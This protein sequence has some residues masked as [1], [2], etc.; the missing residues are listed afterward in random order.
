MMKRKIV[1]LIPDL[2]LGGAQRQCLELASALSKYSCY[3]VSIVTFRHSGEMLHLA[4]DHQL[5]IQNLGFSSG[6][7]IRNSIK[8]RKYLIETN[9]RILVTW[10][11]SADV[12]GFF[13]T[14]FMKVKWI[15]NERDSF[16]PLRI[17]YIARIICCA[18]ASSIIANSLQGV[19]Y[20]K[21]KYFWKNVSLVNN[22]V[23][24]QELSTASNVYDVIFG[25][26]FTTQ[27]RAVETAV[28]LENLVRAKPHL[29]VAMVGDGEHFNQV[30]D[31]FGD[32]IG[33][34]NVDLIGYSIRFREILGSSKTLISLSSHEG[35][36]NVVLEGL[37]QGVVP[38]L[39]DIP[40]HVAI[41]GSDYPFL[42]SD[43]TEIEE[44]VQLVLLAISTEDRRF[45][46]KGNEYLR[47]C[48]PNLVALNAIKVFEEGVS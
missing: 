32:S 8:L 22:I 15:V 34:E 2:S 31:V 45:M 24:P 23:K 36:P 42:I 47:Q 13:A 44:V 9:S 48:Q 17:R 16:Y 1:F 27:K 29:R 28:I 7:D 3:Q 21:R 20:W 35:A 11:H 46:E 14:R 6:F 38:I 40:E 12:I 19:S 4:H 5:E 39:S 26:R 30:R 37:A 10:L 18:F 33:L 41:V 25:G 43:I